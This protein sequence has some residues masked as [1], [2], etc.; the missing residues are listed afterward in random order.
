MKTLL[1]GGP[2]DGEIVETRRND[3][4]MSFVEEVFKRGAGDK[5]IRAVEEKYANAY[6]HVTHPC[7]KKGKVRVFQYVGQVTR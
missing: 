4:G 1:R 6:E 3:F 2:H 5:P 7:K